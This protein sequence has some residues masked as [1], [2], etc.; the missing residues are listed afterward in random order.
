MDDDWYTDGI[1]SITLMAGAAI[2]FRRERRNP[3]YK[4][5]PNLEKKYQG[6]KILECGTSYFDPGSLFAMHG[7]SKYFIHWLHITPVR[8][9]S[10]IKKSSYG[11]ENGKS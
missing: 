11:K 10:K 6:N 2:E 7:E 4:Q 1:V 8:R 9:G 5:Y 3:Y